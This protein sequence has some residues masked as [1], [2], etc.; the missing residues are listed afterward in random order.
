MAA[1]LN[2]PSSMEGKVAFSPLPQ[3]AV[4]KLLDCG[5]A[6]PVWNDYNWGGY[7]IWRGGGRYKVGMDGRAETLYSNQLLKNYFTAG[8][9][10]EGWMKV[11]QRSPARYALTPTAW[12]AHI[13]RLPGWRKLY[14]DDLAILY[15]REGTVW[16]C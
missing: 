10:Q 12:S 6:A 8:L 14:Q 11:V 5:Q 2:L 7:L 15:G 16:R 1:G 13:D 3:R 4:T 9:A